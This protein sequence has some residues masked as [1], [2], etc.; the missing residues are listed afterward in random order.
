M[1]HHST[2]SCFFILENYDNYAFNNQ[3]LQFTLNLCRDGRP[4]ALPV[5]TALFS[6][7]LYSLVPLTVGKRKVVGGCGGGASLQNS[8]RFFEAGREIP[9][10]PDSAR[11]GTKRA[12]G[13]RR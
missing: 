6:I 3:F 13:R 7:C 2:H 12:G 9:R 8:D 5:T 4:G 1:I 10:D 11:R